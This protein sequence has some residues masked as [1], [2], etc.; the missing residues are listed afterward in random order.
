MECLLEARDIVLKKGNRE[1]L[2]VGQFG[3]QEGE[4]LAVVGPNGAGKS[5]L[6]QVL[7]LLQQ[8]ADGAGL[9]RG[10][11]VN[12]KNALGFRRR[13]AVVFQESLLLNTTVF[14]NVAQGLKLRGHSRDEIPSGVNLWLDR[15][16]VSH[17]AHRLPRFLSG[18]E[19]QRVN[20]ARAMVLKPEVLFLDEPFTALDHSTKASLLKDMGS[21]LKESN[22]TAIFVTHDYREIPYLTDNVIV[23]GE[24]QIRQRGKVSTLFGNGFETN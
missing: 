13:M 11:T 10:D 23:M 15:L 6:L 21:I 19:A 1:I 18:G 2:S 17:L 14:N 16:G 5:T 9:F 7:A 20:I 8:P 24:G 22:T 4:V 12:K 3:L